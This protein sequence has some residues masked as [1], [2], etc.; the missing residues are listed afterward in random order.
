MT[1]AGGLGL[2][3]RVGLRA[4]K[5]FHQR[6]GPQA[7]PKLGEP[8]YCGQVAELSLLSWSRRFIIRHSRGSPITAS[9][10]HGELLNRMRRT[11]APEPP[12]R[13]RRE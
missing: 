4:G 8:P 6:L 10:Q 11:S 1:T 12:L 7:A 2:A 9:H 5:V 13:A 3:C